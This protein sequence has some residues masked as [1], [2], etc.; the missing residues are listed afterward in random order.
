MIHF[1][2]WVDHDLRAAC[3]A[4]LTSGLVSRTA[5][6]CPACAAIVEQ[7][8]GRDRMLGLWRSA[9]QAVTA[10]ADAAREAEERTAAIDPG[11]AAPLEDK[12]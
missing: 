9:V 10:A 3:G 6:H 2:E 12:C 5:F 4:P 7:Q 8:A 11:S 1:A